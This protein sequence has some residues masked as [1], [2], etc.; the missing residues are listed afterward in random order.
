M[1]LCHKVK[2]IIDIFH[3]FDKLNLFSI[4]VRDTY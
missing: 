2:I 4:I 1:F 3:T